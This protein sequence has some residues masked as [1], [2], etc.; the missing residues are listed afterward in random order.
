[1]GTGQEERDIL[2]EY[3]EFALEVTHSSIWVVDLD[4][5]T[6]KT[7][8]GPAADVFNFETAELDTVEPFFEEGIHPDDVATVVSVYQDIL[9]DERDQY[10]VEYRTHPDNGEIRWL[11]TYARVKDTEQG[12]ILIGTSTDITERKRD[13]R[14]LEAQNE[15]LEEFASV[16]S[17]DLQNPL[18]VAMGHVELAQEETDTEHLDT[19]ARML[20]QMEDLT[21]DLLASIEDG[22]P[23]IRGGGTTDTFE[24]V[25]L[26]E[27]ATTSWEATT[28]DEA[29]LQID[30]EQT[31]HADRAS[32]QQLFENLFRNAVE[33]GG[34]DV[35]VTIGSLDDASG[36]YVADDGPGIPD[37]ERTRIFDAGYSTSETGTG[38]GLHIVKNIVEAQEWE[39]SVTESTMG[40]ARF[41]VRGV[42]TT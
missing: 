30:T 20:V 38:L 22:G 14:E 42:S 1:M 27:I 18:H 36:F 35:T 21:D 11:E 39:I 16:L 40:G 2:F 3:V 25:E 37:R 29:T 28:T 33:H 10:R 15:R 12:R 6:M 31:I 5:G 41:D 24:T 13:E 9:T 7:Q 4:T 19:V 17:H 26:S 8:L 23:V 32:L 34:P